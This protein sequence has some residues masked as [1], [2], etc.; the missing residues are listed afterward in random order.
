MKKILMFLFLICLSLFIVN[1]AGN[2]DYTIYYGTITLSDG[3]TSSDVGVGQ[4]LS[5]T[6]DS[7]DAGSTTISTTG[8]YKLIVTKVSDT[9][10]AIVFTLSTPS[11]YDSVTESTGETYSTSNNGNYVSLNL[12]FSGTPTTAAAPS[13]EAPGRRGGAI[14]APITPEVLTKITDL[15]TVSDVIGSLPEGWTNIDVYQVGTPTTET[16]T[17]AL[18]DLLTAALTHATKTEA[19]GVLQNVQNK[20]EA[21]EVNQISAT[22]TLD[23]YKITNKDTG[24]IVYRTKQTI[25]FTAPTNL[26][27]VK[28]IETIPHAVV[29]SVDELHFPGIKPEVLQKDPVLQWIFE[30]V[31]KDETKSVEYIV[32]KK[33]D[34]IDSKTV[35]IATEEIEKSFFPA[36]TKQTIGIIIIVIIVLVGLVIY[37]Q[38]LKK[39]EKKGVKK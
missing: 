7:T 24:E 13:A 17:E 35:I 30:A 32:K 38:Y 31:K 3:T 25:T 4:T 26:K 8:E 10:N 23:V 9:T 6:M 15:T 39:E 16:I 18:T 11:G 37:Y 2:Q 19:I 5:A 20:L 33:L 27:Y 22:K 14:V 34:K 28:I 1:A 29:A 36:L 12:A 21:K